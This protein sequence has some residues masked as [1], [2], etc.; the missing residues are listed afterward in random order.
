LKKGRKYSG[1]DEEIEV[2][3]KHPFLIYRFGR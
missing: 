2:E 1:F 3:D